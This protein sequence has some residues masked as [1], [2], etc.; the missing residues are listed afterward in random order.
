MENLNEKAEKFLDSLKANKL[1][2]GVNYLGKYVQAHGDDGSLIEG[3]VQSARLD[4]G[5][6][7]LNVNG[8]EIMPSNII[9]I[10]INND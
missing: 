7:K 2:E 1:T 4:N 10:S 5:T 9:T 3:V 8:Q 6:L